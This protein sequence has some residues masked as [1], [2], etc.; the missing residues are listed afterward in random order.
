VSESIGIE[1]VN[2]GKCA[3]VEDAPSITD[4]A[5]GLTT[6]SA[7]ALTKRGKKKK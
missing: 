6:K 2:M 7:A 5:I 3:P 1:L 4:R